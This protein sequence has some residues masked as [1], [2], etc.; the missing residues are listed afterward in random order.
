V[1]PLQAQ[2]DEAMDLESGLDAARRVAASFDQAWQSDPLAPHVTVSLDVGSEGQPVFLFALLLELSDELDPKDF[3][4]EQVEK[5]KSDLRARI[6]SSP[7]DRW[8]S[9][10]MVRAKHG[11]Q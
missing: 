3:P 5:L 11:I 10:V 9:V 6:A 4:G 1:Q 2:N 7:M 8:Q